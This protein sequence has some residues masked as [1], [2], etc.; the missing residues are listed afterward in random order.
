MR[1]TEKD[2]PTI[3]ILVP[4][5]GKAQK[6]T[7]KDYEK[8]A[9]A[10]AKAILQVNALI[11]SETGKSIKK[12]ICDD[13]G[14]HV[15]DYETPEGFSYLNQSLLIIY[16]DPSKT[17][18]E[19]A[20]CLVEQRLLAYNGPSKIFKEILKGFAERLAEKRLRKKTTKKKQ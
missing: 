9:E 13:T 11:E 20:E 16:N 1:N 7:G 2:Y 4:K 12:T 6:V 5:E 3:T 14:T 15:F 8:A 19:I 18:E 17:I 10:V